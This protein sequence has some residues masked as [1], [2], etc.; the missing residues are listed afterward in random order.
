M[1]YAIEA[2][3]LVKRYGE[4]TALNG[5]DLAVPA[6]SVLGVLGPNGAGKTTAVRILAT[7]LRPD[8]GTARIGGYDIRRQAHEIRRI[9]GLAG[10]YASVDEDLSGLHNLT[11]V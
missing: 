7:L 10:Q 5:V 6:G 4:V 9:I 3:G 2:T 11:M 1:T 8:A